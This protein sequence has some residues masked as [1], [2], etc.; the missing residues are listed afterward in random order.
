MGFEPLISCQI[1]RTVLIKDETVRTNYYIGTEPWFMF[2]T[3][4]RNTIRLCRP[5]KSSCG[6]NRQRHELTYTE[7]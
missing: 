7:Y 6:D 5:E 4:E 1:Y 2:E 3:V